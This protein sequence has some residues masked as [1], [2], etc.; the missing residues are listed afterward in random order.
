MTVDKAKLRELAE[1]SKEWSG[2]IGCDE[3]YSADEFAKPYISATDAKFIE[4]ATPVAILDL[5][6]EIESWRGALA[7]AQAEIAALKQK[8]KEL[9]DQVN[10]PNP[11]W[12]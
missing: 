11:E 6:D 12:M 3:W 5:L 7:G 2:E 9:W 4:S 8:N 10:Q 1:A